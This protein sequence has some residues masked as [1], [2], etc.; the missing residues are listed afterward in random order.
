MLYEIE[1]RNKRLIVIA[2]KEELY[3][4][5]A[6]PMYMQYFGV[7]PKAMI[8]ISHNSSFILLNEIMNFLLCNGTS[9]IFSR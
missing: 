3:H 6:N 7:L 9:Y 8:P 4:S 2:L 5:Y 1:V